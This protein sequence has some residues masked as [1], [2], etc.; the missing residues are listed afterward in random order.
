MVETK[1]CKQCEKKFEVEDSDLEFY[2]KISPTFDGKIFDIPSPQLCP[3]C[4]LIRRMVWRNERKLYNNK[5]SLCEKEIV[6]VY[7]LDK[8][9]K[10]ICPECFW[11]DKW[12]QLESG[13]DYNSDKS[14]FEQFNDL[15]HST[16]LLNLFS[17]NCENCGYCNQE[18]NSVDSYLC[19]GGNDNRNCFHCNSCIHG[20]DMTDCWGV[21][22]SEKVHNSVFSVACFN[23][24]YLYNCHMCKDCYFLNDCVGCDHCFGS[25]NLRYKKYYF[26]NKRLDKD[27]YFK[28]IE[29]YLYSYEGIK[30]AQKEFEKHK[31]KFPYKYVTVIASKED[32]T[33]D[34]LL[35]SKSVKDSYYC[36]ASENARYVY[37]IANMKDVMDILSTGTG[38]LSYEIASSTKPYGSAF[39]TSCDLVRNSYYCYNCTSSN[40]LFGCVSLNKKQ[41]CIFNKQYTKEEYE[42]EVARIITSM[43]K[44]GEWGE[45]FP[46]SISPFAYNESN[47]MEHFPLKRDEAKK[48]GF[49]WQDKDY[50]M[51]YDGPYYEPKDI[52]EYDVE[53]DPKADKEIEKCIRGIIKCEVSGKLFK[54]IP[55]EMV[56]YI[57]NKLQLPRKHPDVRYRERLN[58]FNKMNLYHRQCMCE[59]EGHGHNGQCKVEF[60]TTF[61]PERKEKVYCGECYQ[62]SVI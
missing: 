60:E 52:K 31:L 17:T 2:K 24:Q 34:I 26:F 23:C 62:G 36:Y 27:E 45:F 44:R 43:I 16:Y 51:K 59:E 3:Q 15:I 38:E 56:Q 32:C 7:S 10:V 41:Y 14:F 19:T 13:R 12:D 53:H 61:E 21:G 54:I 5:C 37:I 1:K 46:A 55:Q 42:K 22:F 4:R 25:T 9:F 39:F 40:D 28:K 33:G 20:N 50:S 11:S 29:E 30:K 8:K 18:I 35:N 57:K 49:D 48:E 58:M 6:S 47:A